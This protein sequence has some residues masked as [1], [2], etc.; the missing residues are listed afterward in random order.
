MDLSGQHQ[1]EQQLASHRVMRGDQSIND[2]FGQR[3]PTQQVAAQCQLPAD[4]PN[5][6][7]LAVED[8]LIHDSMTSRCR[9]FPPL[10]FNICDFVRPAKNIT[11][12]PNRQPMLL[13]A[14]HDR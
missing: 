14:K 13:N 2:S 7:P 6:I 10:I 1:V 3:R 8:G 9:K 11:G 4:V 5:P 12:I